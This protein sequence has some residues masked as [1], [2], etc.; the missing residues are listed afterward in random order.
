MS[1]RHKDQ[2]QVLPGRP[3]PEALP[4]GQ[5]GLQQP[6]RRPRSS[7]IQRRQRAAR[8]LHPPEPRPGGAGL[9][10]GQRHGRGGLLGGP[11][12]PGYRVQKL[13]R[14]E[15]SDPS[16]GWRSLAELRRPVRGLRGEVAGRELPRG[17]AL[18]LPVQHSLTSGHSVTPVEALG[19]AVVVVSR[20]RATSHGVFKPVVLS[21]A[22][23]RTQVGI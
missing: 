22:R 21:W 23:I 7:R 18:R 16:A 8:R 14:V 12:W 17:E 19:V 20:F 13:G 11:E 5:R 9:A 10:G 6:G 15:R 1:E 4:R 2:R 3:R